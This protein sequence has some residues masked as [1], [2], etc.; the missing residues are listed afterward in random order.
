MAMWASKDSSFI[1]VH[2]EK[3]LDL[4]A[5]PLSPISNWR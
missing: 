5:I 4:A 2:E 1:S 3:K